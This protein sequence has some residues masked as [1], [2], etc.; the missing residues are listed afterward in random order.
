MLGFVMRFFFA[1]CLFAFLFVACYDSGYN[2]NG[3]CPFY[4]NETK[5]VVK[6]FYTEK[7]PET[8]GV[9]D[10]IVIA[11]FDSVSCSCSNHMPSL[12]KNGMRVGENDKLTDVKLIF[13]VGNDSL[14]CLTFVGDSLQENDIRDF[15]MYENLGECDSC[16]RCSDPLN[17][18]LYRI[19]D[20]MLEAAEPCE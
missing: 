13:D 12:L 20:E 14:R 9:T 8:E 5:A 6:I 4:R 16:S 2:E 17:A 19:T 1:F 15:S 7:W 10:S 11:T 3:Y 18:M